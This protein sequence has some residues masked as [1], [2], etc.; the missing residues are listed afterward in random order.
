MPW[1]LHNDKESRTTIRP[2]STNGGNL[3]PVGNDDIC[4]PNQTMDMQRERAGV[5]VETAANL[6]EIIRINNKKQAQI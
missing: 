3:H 1:Q 6:L 5:R 2:F 4:G